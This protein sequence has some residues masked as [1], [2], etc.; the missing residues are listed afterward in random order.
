MLSQEE[1]KSLPETMKYGVLVN[2][3]DFDKKKVNILL[4][5]LYSQN[6]N[7]MLIRSLLG[8]D[9]KLLEFLDILA[10]INLKLPTHTTLLKVINEIE[11]W[12]TLRRQDLSD[13]TVKFVSNNYKVPAAKVRAIY[14]EYES[15]FG[16]DH[17]GDK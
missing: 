4:Q 7:I 13:A 15:K 17:G 6:G 10:G 8:T 2:K 11:I 16:D 14:E 5:K 9:E 3:K 1:L 12:S